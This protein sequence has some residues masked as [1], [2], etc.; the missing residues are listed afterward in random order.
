MEET[1]DF[2]E[3]PDSDAKNQLIEIF[4]SFCLVADCDPSEAN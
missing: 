4:S 3:W 2:W 1:F